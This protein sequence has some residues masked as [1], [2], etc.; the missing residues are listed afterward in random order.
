MVWQAVPQKLVEFEYSQPYI[1]PA[2]RITNTMISVKYGRIYVQRE[3]PGSGT[4]NFPNRSNNF[5]IDTSK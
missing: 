3:E 1:P 4:K 2:S 5:F